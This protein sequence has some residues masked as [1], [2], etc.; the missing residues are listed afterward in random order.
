MGGGM[1]L[2]SRGDELYPDNGSGER[3][4]ERERQMITL[5][6]WPFFYILYMAFFFNLYI[7]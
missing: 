4:G 6:S 1:E 5:N 3:D 7:K 2:D